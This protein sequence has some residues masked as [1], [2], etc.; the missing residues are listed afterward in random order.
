MI[1]LTSLFISIKYLEKTYPG[2]NQLLSFT[3]IPYCYEE[4]VAQEKDMLLTLD[5]QIQFVPM[6][7]ILG[8]FLCQGVLFTSDRLVT[9]RAPDL[10]TTQ[11]L[12]HNCD[13]L[14]TLC[15]KKQVFLKYD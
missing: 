15:I 13:I 14:S 2:I 7:T 1:A 4:F 5:W 8:H 3:G 12:S 11:V 10:D 9:K 6:H